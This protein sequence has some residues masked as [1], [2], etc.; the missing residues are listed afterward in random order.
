MDYLTAL[1]NGMSPSTPLNGCE[2]N[3]SVNSKSDWATAG[4]SHILFAP[5]VGFLLLSCPWVCQG[6]AWGVLNQSKS[7]II[8]KK[9]AI[10]ALSLKQEA[11]SS[12]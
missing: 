2:I 12:I 11:L 3:V 4:D 10:F 8:L 5:E 1:G 6:F 7:W 9:S